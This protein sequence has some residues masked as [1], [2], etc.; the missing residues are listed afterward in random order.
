MNCPTPFL[1]YRLSKVPNVVAIKD[2]TGGLDTASEMFSSTKLNPNFVL[3]SGDDG[4]TV[5]F[6]S[7]GA[8]GVISVLS[9]YMPER[10]VEMVQCALDNN[11]KKAGEIH[12]SL[13]PLVKTLFIETNP[14]PVK[15]A[16]KTKGL[17]PHETVRLP[18]VT[19]TEDSREKLTKTLSSYA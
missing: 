2:A 11:I 18:L 6:C 5:P 19:L 8:K 7:I 1:V 3:L 17:L 12:T 10:T 16:M 9:N 13:F 14:V 15:A 4:L